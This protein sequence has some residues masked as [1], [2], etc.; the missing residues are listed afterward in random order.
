[1]TAV[2]RGY[3]FLCNK[4]KAEVYQLCK[5]RHVVG[6]QEKATEERDLFL[7]LF[8]LCLLLF[9]CFPVWNCLPACWGKGWVVD[10]S[11]VGQ[12]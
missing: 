8:A 9:P 7:L 10:S 4:D 6:L 1:M 11:S 2:E 3:L 12:I 5:C